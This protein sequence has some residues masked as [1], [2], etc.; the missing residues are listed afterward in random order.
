[1]R[2]K[3]FTKQIGLILSEETYDQLIEQTNREEKTISEWIRE[4]VEEKLFSGKKGV[5]SSISHQTDDGEQ[6]QKRISFKNPCN[7][8]S[9]I[10]CHVC[11][12]HIS[13][14]KPFGGPGDPLVGDFEG[15]LLV[16]T[17]RSVSPVDEEA[18]KALAGFEEEPG[19]EGDLHAWLISKYGKEKGEQFYEYER[20]GR[21]IDKSWECRDCILLDNNE[22]FKKIG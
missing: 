5:A 3:H 21:I 13:Q 14:L 11:G 18:E 17:Y 9:D 16:K 20:S 4:A 10:C 6:E 15:Q 12:K 2:K 19:Y 8:P 22:Y 7:L 1:M